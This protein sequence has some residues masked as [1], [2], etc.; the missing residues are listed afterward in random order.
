M[1]VHETPSPEASA[2]WEV[3]GGWL[4]PRRLTFD[5]WVGFRERCNVGTFDTEA[6]VRTPMIDD[7]LGDLLLVTSGA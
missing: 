5:L 3:E 1:G 4:V 6:L 7:G 2:W